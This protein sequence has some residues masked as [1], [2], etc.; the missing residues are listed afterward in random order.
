[1]LPFYVISPII[2][3]EDSTDEKQEFLMIQILFTA[4]LFFANIYFFKS[5]KYPY[6]FVPCMLFLPDF[7]GIEFSSSFPLLTVSRIMFIVFY[8]YVFINKRANFSLKQMFSSENSL[9]L[10]YF[11]IRIISNL[12][13]VTT[14]IQPIKTI[15]TLVIEQLLFL[16]AFY[17]LSFTQA[18]LTKLIKVI[19][20]SASVLFF[21]GI[22]ESFTEIRVFNFLYSV[23]R[24]MLNLYYVRLGLLRSVTTMGIPNLYGNL[25]AFM[26]PMI[27]YLLRTTNEKKYCVLM[28]LNIL[29][30]IHS[31]CRSD[32]II[33]IILTVIYAI[34]SVITK[35]ALLQFIK[36]ASIIL[37]ML[38]AW[39]M[40]LSVSNERYSYYYST[41]VKS[42]LNIVGFDFDLNAGAPDGVDG[43]G[44][45]IEGVYSRTFQFSAVEDAMSKN[46]LFGLGSGCA[47]RGELIYYFYNDYHQGFSFDLGIVEV[48]CSEGIIGLT[49][50]IS[51][52]IW[53]TIKLYKMARK[54]GL[55]NNEVILMLS[56]FL[57]YLLST[58]STI[59]MQRFLS[60]ITALCMSYFSI[61]N[62]IINAD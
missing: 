40:I 34:F 50:Y 47:S 21:F 13:Y 16:V 49:A 35:K 17:M 58:L 42:V 61:K 26:A 54:V 12:Y 41:T 24:D 14:Y 28:F 39:I 4:A 8:V 31:G 48:L 22:I 59:N 3:L 10:S 6:L 53:Y 1:M 44:K 20:W 18:E 15:L 32:L 60:L 36:N 46:P 56:L 7:Y 62:K 33:L 30:T 25:C 11:L 19:V 5:K 55:L 51:L 38:L 23:S 29:A 27:L 52:F 2:K 37:I 9:L 57:T 43:Y 45:N